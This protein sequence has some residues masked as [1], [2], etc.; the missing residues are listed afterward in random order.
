MNQ[1]W[2][3]C[4]SAPML[5]TIFSPE[6]C[7]R[8]VAATA[9]LILAQP[10]FSQTERF[11][12]ELELASSWQAKNDIQIPNDSS[13]TRF[14]A[15]DI[16]GNGAWRSARLNALYNFD[17]KHALRVVLAPFSFTETGLSDIPLRYENQ[18]FQANQPL[19]T[20]YRFNSW[21]VGYRYHF[22]ERENFDMWLGVSAKIRDAEISLRQ[23]NL[24]ATNDDVGFVPLLYFAT[25]YR[26]NSK[27]SVFADVDGLAGGPGRAF[28][29][30]VKLNY[31]VND[32]WKFGIGYRTLEGGVDNE[33]VYNFTWFNS[34]LLSLSRKF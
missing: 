10:V 13:G 30:G 11:S 33:D 19:Q 24:R 20:D 21:R 22:L 1:D 9:S 4:V 32:D 28:D 2:F 3:A 6:S 16:V 31:E 18:S 7:A 27:W 5:T 25:E 8:I 12:I 34:A 23:Q 14:S 29:I 15:R 17:N 26:W